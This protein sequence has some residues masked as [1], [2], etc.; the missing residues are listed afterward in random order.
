MPSVTP[1]T[2]LDLLSEVLE[3]TPDDDTS[4][5][6]HA[7]LMLK[8][9]IEETYLPDALVADALIGVNVMTG[10]EAIRQIVT[11]CTERGHL[12]NCR[13]LV[14]WRAGGWLSQG[15]EIL[16][17]AGPYPKRLRETWTDGDAPRFRVTLNLAYW[18]LASDH[19]RLRLMH[20]ELGHCGINGS[21]NPVTVHHDREEFVATMARFGPQE[22]A[23]IMMADACLAHPDTDSK[24]REWDV[25]G[26]GQVLLFPPW[27]G[28][29]V[30][31][32]ERAD[33]EHDLARH[34]ALAPAVAAAIDR[35]LAAAAAKPV[36]RT[37]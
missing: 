11:T 6:L 27:D 7:C 17:K 21:G 15:R 10:E 24:R 2:L 20:H 16:G 12:L 29:A 36:G 34:R 9:V 37:L 31:D 14:E 19:E 4:E 8:E 25:N 23:D 18:L 13:I 33:I 26:D 1:D 32:R 5:H 22:P 28:P 30:V 35:E 3:S